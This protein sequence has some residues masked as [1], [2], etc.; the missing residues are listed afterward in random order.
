[1]AVLESSCLSGKM[2]RILLCSV[3]CFITANTHKVFPVDLNI[4]S[5]GFGVPLL[6]M[7]GFL[8]FLFQNL[9]IILCQLGQM[10][11]FS[12]TFQY[13][14][15]LEPLSHS[16]YDLFHT[17]FFFSLKYLPRL[18]HLESFL[19]TVRKEKIMFL[20]QMTNRTVLE[21]DEVQGW[22]R[23]LLSSQILVPGI[24]EPW[25]YVL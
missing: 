5:T 4:Y 22:D 1:M 13:L 9:R 12:L 8:W 25:C 18:C 11:R 14:A 19:L 7:S 17:D 2:S 24:E 15:Y 20:L 6:W 16:L 3:Q 10:H 23:M 21:G